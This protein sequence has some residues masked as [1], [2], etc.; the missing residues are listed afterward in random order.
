MIVLV[1]ICALGSL[2]VVA[3]VETETVGGNVSSVD[4]AYSW[5]RD[6]CND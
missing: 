5:S 4:A 6:C 2:I 1:F 3:G